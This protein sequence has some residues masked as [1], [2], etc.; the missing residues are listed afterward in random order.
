V[1]LTVEP[2]GDKMPEPNGSVRAGRGRW[3]A[4]K[5]MPG[6]VALMASRPDLEGMSVAGWL[7]E[8]LRWGV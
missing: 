1:T 3:N 2:E 4:E 7:D 8:V 6:A 5:L